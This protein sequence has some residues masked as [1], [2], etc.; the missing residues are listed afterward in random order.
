MIN[1]LEEYEQKI[2]K[3]ERTLNSMYSK[4]TFSTIAEVL[5]GE[6][7]LRGLWKTSH[8]LYMKISDLYREAYD[9]LDSEFDEYDDT[10]GLDLKIDDINSRAS[11]KADALSDLIDVL[12]KISEVDDEYGIK[13]HF[14]DIKQYKI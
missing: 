8:N 9:W 13:K 11:S 2:A 7:D 14:Q 6:I 1:S 3:I 5:E 4:L 10:G 12:G